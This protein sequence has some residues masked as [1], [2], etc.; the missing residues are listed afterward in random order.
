MCTCIDTV[1]VLDLYTLHYCDCISVVVD[2]VV[3]KY[4]SFNY[5]FSK[6]YIQQTVS[7][8]VPKKSIW[9]MK[10]EM[11][12]MH[13]LTDLLWKVKKWILLFFCTIKHIRETFKSILLPF[14]ICCYCCCVYCKCR[15]LYNKIITKKRV[16]FL[17]NELSRILNSLGIGDW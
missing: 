7:V 14:L 15:D 12:D 17:I 9:N 4:D 3:P 2:V 6:P 16:L 10:A 5:Y 13:W 1:S 8:F 11:S